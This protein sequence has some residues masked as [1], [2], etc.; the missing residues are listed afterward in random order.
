MFTDDTGNP[1]STYRFHSSWFFNTDEF[2][3]NIIHWALQLAAPALT[4]TNTQA[5]TNYTDNTTGTGA[6]ANRDR[7]PHGDVVTIGFDMYNSAN[8][9]PRGTASNTVGTSTAERQVKETARVRTLT[10]V[11]EL[12]THAGHP[13][14]Y[15]P[16]R[17][18]TNR[19]QTREGDRRYLDLGSGDNT[20]IANVPL[21]FA[22]RS[23]AL[24]PNSPN[25]QLR[26]PDLRPIQNSDRDTALLAHLHSRIVS[27]QLSQCPEE[28]EYVQLFGTL[29]GTSQDAP[30]IFHLI[31][32]TYKTSI[33]FF[34]KAVTLR[35]QNEVV[36]Q[37][38][39]EKE[40]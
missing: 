8:N 9:V 32:K 11:P 5:S 34:F 2:L 7:S 40:T 37:D 1:P 27:V 31:L 6:N 28:C 3:V 26:C 25:A 12:D 21:P 18:N 14:P 23:L 29:P 24:G 20:S 13:Q 10:L 35:V 16:F 33:G 39:E 36:L 19:S 22:N 4:D 30:T 15:L 38:E 17:S